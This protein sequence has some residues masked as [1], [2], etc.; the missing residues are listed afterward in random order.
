MFPTLHAA[1]GSDAPPTIWSR[2]FLAIPAQVRE[3]R[4]FLASILAGR[5]AADDATLC[6]SELASNAAVHSRSREP[7]GHFTVCVQVTEA[8]RI[9]VEVV[10]EGGPW[11]Q[12]V[13]G[14]GQHGRG[15]LIVSQLARDWGRTGDAA[16]GW[17]VWFEMDVLMTGPGDRPEQP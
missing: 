8:G 17:T 7:G 12:P 9:R 1:A 14:D 11:T 15:L 3:A 6:L 5:P 10:D 4:R 13:R 2:V 16:T